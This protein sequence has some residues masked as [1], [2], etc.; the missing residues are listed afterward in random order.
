[1]MNTGR[2]KPY[3]FKIF[4]FLTL[5]PIVLARGRQQAG[6]PGNSDPAFQNP[7]FVDPEKNL[8]FNPEPGSNLKFSPGPVPKPGFSNSQPET[9]KPDSLPS[10][11]LYH[12]A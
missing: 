9:R 10:P 12:Y 8:N 5:Y 7:D 2:K 1:M 6:R 11:A 4:A 3:L